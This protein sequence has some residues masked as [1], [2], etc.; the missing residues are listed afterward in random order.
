MPTSDWL[1]PGPRSTPD[2]PAAYW[3]DTGF[4][5]LPQCPL[6]DERI[7]E[8]ERA[9][10]PKA[11]DVPFDLGFYLALAEH[12]QTH[13]IQ[14][15]AFSYGRFQTRI[16]QA[17]TEIAEAFFRL[18]TPEQ[19]RGIFLRRLKGESLLQ[20]DDAQR[21][22]LRREFGPI[23][24]RL[25]RHWWA[26]GLL[27]HEL[28]TADYELGKLQSTRFRFGL[29]SLYAE[30]G[31]EISKVALLEDAVLTDAVLEGAPDCEPSVALKKSDAPRFTTASIV[32]CAAVL[33]QHWF[34]A[35]QAE[36]CRRGEKPSDADRWWSTLVRSWE[37]KELSFYSDA[38]TVYST[39]NPSLD[40]NATVPLATLGVLCSVSLDGRFP[41]E[42]PG[43]AR[44]EDLAP[45]L[46]FVALSQ[47]VKKVGLLPA[48]S[49]CALTSA[50]YQ[51]YVDKL[52]DAATIAPPLPYPSERLAPD[53][54]ARSPTNDLR[55]LHHEAATAAATL[56]HAIPAAIVAPAEANVYREAE[57]LTP[58]ME[59]LR[60]AREAPLLIMGGVASSIGIDDDRF[61][62]CAIAGAY[63]RM[64]LQL[65][66]D[67]KCLR[68]T[69]LP[70]DE[71]G[72]DIVDT[73]FRVAEV[74][75]GASIPF[76][77]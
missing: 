26:L 52:C 22:V 31:P 72:G 38:F 14:A 10:A 27:R 56:L 41:V 46:R 59:P 69:G 12:E 55:H 70:T 5:E 57:L 29:S 71:R 35:H 47:A 76:E 77:R 43:V 11:S 20:L 51:E 62:R 24:A 54:W 61:W 33:N 32:E 16:D 45:P 60:L 40:L 17:R 9:G 7:D 39:H 42:Q 44:W 53:R 21:P 49:V 34:Y 50:R 66:A 3:P 73:M 30:A 58:E 18:F 74:I 67:P 37:S 64:M 8:L 75:L 63:Q 28:D 25:Q 48:H 68:M 4:L 36:A 65:F 19:L 2:D 1:F 13:W 15:H 23:G 6:T